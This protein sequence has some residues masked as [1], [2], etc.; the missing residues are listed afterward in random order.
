[1]SRFVFRLNTDN[2]VEIMDTDFAEEYVSVKNDGNS[3]IITVSVVEED[4]E[5]MDE[6]EGI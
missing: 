3:K 6:E 2:S 1:M 4:L 5:I